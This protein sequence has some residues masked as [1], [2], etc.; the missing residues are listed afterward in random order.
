M[1]NKS[2]ALTE[3]LEKRAVAPDFLRETLAFMLQELMEHEVAELCGADRHERSEER[4][5]RRN[6][7]RERPLESMRRLRPIDFARFRWV[8][9]LREGLL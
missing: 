8:M 2:M 6:G 4:V 3:L 5:N 7:Y 9:R 1:T